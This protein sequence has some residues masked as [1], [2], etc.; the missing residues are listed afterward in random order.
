MYETLIGYAMTPSE[1]SRFEELEARQKQSEHD[2][3]ALT[4]I[5]SGLAA[6]VASLL[7]V[8][9]AVEGAFKVLEFIGKAAK[10]LAWCIAMGAAIVAVWNAVAGK[11]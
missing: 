10:P 8:M 2:I 11:H 4:S 6:N 3:A 9:Q 1:F 7:S 5:A